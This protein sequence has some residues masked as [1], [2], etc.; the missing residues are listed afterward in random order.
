[1]MKR[2]LKGVRINEFTFYFPYSK[3]TTDC[4]DVK[5]I[6]EYLPTEKA[7]LADFIFF[8]IIIILFGGLVLTLIWLH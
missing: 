4:D 8:I 5:L 3:L 6:A 1:M 7:S 2:R